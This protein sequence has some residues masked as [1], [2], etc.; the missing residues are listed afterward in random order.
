MK[1]TRYYN[2]KDELEIMDMKIA[3]SACCKIK[4]EFLIDAR[5]ILLA[6]TELNDEELKKVSRKMVEKE[7]KRQL[8]MKGESWYTSP[9]NDG[10]EGN[11][12]FNLKDN[13]EKALPI[14]KKLFPEFF[15]TPN[16]IKFIKEKH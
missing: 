7:L 5:H 2:S 3:S 16:S 13:L 1:A 14:G 15:D 4:V 12:F 6:I 11:Y 9:I 10:E 8:E